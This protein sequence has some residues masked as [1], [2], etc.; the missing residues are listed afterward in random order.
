MF[1]GM[2]KLIDRDVEELVSAQL[3]KHGRISVSE[4]IDI[5]DEVEARYAPSN[6]LNASREF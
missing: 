6:I 4:L 3:A 1:I 5:Y 2:T